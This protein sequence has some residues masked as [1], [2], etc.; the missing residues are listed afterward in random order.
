MNSSRKVI[1]DD[2]A[3][4]VGVSAITV[5][6][7]LRAPH[8]VSERLRKKIALAVDELGYVPDAAARA[9]ASNRTNVI[10]VIIP[11][12][13]NNVFID[14]LSGIYAGLEDTNY[15]VQFVNTRYSS[16]KEEALLRVFLNQKPAGLVVTGVDQTEQSRQMLRKAPCP[17]VQIMEID[18]EP[19][20]LMVG[21]SH[22]EAARAATN[23]LIEQ[24]YRHPAFIGARMDPRSQRRLRGFRDAATKAGLFDE[25]RVHTTLSASSVTLGAQLFGELV[26]RHPEVDAVF[27]NN[28]D[29]A[30]GVLF[31]AK[32]RNVSIPERIGLCG[33]NDF[34]MMATAE[35]PITSVRTFRKEMGEIAIKMILDNLEGIVCNEKI[36]DLGFEVCKRRSTG[37]VA[38]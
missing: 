3:A 29:L 24:G 22:Y 19:I 30:L 26:E 8:M 5:S 10:G 27:C 20:D 6:R 9:L 36:V 2:V 4:R 12:M 34:E 23:H 21:I 14:V 7:A 33:F 13:T 1:L 31:E 38:T 28:D 25:S 37:Q 16:L 15:E 32:R 18:N 35:P 17:I 11:S